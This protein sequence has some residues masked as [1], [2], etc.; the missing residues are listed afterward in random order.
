MSNIEN[1]K[2]TLKVHGKEVEQLQVN[3]SVRTL[4][5]WMAPSLEWKGQFEVMRNKLLESMR[6]L[7]NKEIKMWQVHVYYHIYMIKSVF[8]GYGV[9]KLN[10]KQFRELEKIYEGPMLKKINL[11]EKFPR[12]LMYVDKRACGLGLMRPKTTMD[13]LKLKLHIGNG[14]L[15]SNVNDVVKVNEE[16]AAVFCGQSELCQNMPSTET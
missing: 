13:I 12:T 7:I 8:F 16:K 9:V 15:E 14:R 3:K 1:A 11:S 5:A 2:N 10:E 6:K 4:G